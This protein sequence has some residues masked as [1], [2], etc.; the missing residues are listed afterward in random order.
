MRNTLPEPW[1]ALRAKYQTIGKMCRLIGIP[2]RTFYN[3][4]HGKRAP[5]ASGQRILNLFLEAH[6]FPPFI[7]PPKKGVTHEQSP[8]D[9]S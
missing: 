1:I 8:D 3:W 9:L 5:G 4:I 6:G 2:T 7:P